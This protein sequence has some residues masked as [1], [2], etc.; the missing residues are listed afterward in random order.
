MLRLAPLFAL[1]LLAGC[2]GPAAQLQE[3]ATPLA[4]NDSVADEVAPAP[5]PE[6]GE[7]EWVVT[8]TRVEPK[9]YSAEWSGTL[10]ARPCAPDG[11]EVC[12]GGA[13]NAAGFAAGI[14][15]DEPAQSF[16]D[17][18][19]LF[20]RL[21][22]QVDWHTKNPL[23]PGVELD[24]FTITDCQECEHRLIETFAGGAPIRVEHYD[25]FLEP[26]EYGVELVVRAARD[27]IMESTWGE[28]AVDFDVSGYVTAFVA[29]GETVVMA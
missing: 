18:D 8:A 4:A 25:I 10:G 26:G 21:D 2:A 29:A 9:S 19:G 11:S 13:I 24:V 22:V 14:T 16:P 23:V 7:D 17:R 12:R 28:A 6:A 20:W 27:A 5:E 15:W 3:T 1:L